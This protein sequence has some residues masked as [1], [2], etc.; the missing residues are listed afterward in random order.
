MSFEG[1]SVLS[2]GCHFVQRAKDFSYLVGSQ[3]GII[4]VKSESNWSKA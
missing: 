3:P 4:S 2:S 1:F